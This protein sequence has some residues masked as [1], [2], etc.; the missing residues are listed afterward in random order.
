MKTQDNNADHV[1]FDELSVQI[2]VASEHAGKTASFV[3]GPSRAHLVKEVVNRVL[4]KLWKSHRDGN[5]PNNV[6]AWVKTVAR[7][8]AYETLRV[9]ERY[10][11]SLVDE[12]ATEDSEFKA[13]YV[14]V[15]HDSLTPATTTE[16]NERVAALKTL[17]STFESVA[18]NQLN[19]G[20]ALLFE[21]YYRRGAKADQIAFEL[22]VTEEAIRKQWSRLLTKV[23]ETVRFQLKQDPLCSDLLSTLL[24]NEEA[25]RDGFLGVL[26]V[27]KSHGFEE[28]E[29]LVYTV[30]DD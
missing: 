27:V 22:D 19:A 2:P 13:N 18:K 10:P 15:P 7:R 6:T 12:L 11:K 24:A 26:R 3:F 23:L 25:F 28:L 16:F 1:T 17:L 8:L 4:V 21:F 5:P 20:E 29:R 30:F 14:V 9:E